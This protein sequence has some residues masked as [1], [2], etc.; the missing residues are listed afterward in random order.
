ME[1]HKHGLRVV[2]KTGILLLEVGP[3]MVRDSPEFAEK[4]GAIAAS[5]S[6]AEVNLYCLFA[7]LLGITPEEAKTELKKYPTAAMATCRAREIAAQSLDGAELASLNVWYRV[8]LSYIGSG[9][10]QPLVMR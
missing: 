6:Q 3:H 5:W 4:I 2:D 10:W 9:A 7:V 1:Q 8:I